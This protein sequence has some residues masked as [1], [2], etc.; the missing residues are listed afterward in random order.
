LSYSVTNA[1]SEAAPGGSKL[2]LKENSRDVGGIRG[3]KLKGIFGSPI[4]HAI[5]HC[6]AMMSSVQQGDGGDVICAR[7]V[8]TNEQVVSSTRSRSSS[9]IPEAVKLIQHEKDNKRHS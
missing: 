8:E 9:E 5:T 6:T 1:E 7:D 4:A 2:P 3:S